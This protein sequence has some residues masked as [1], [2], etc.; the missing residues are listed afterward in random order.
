MQKLGI[1]GKCDSA[2]CGQG[3]VE[4]RPPDDLTL[5]QFYAMKAQCMIHMTFEN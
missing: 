3:R 5:F 1:Y 4:R 2:W